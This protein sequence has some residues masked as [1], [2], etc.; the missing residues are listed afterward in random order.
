MTYYQRKPSMFQEQEIPL[1]LVHSLFDQ[2][3]KVKNHHRVCCAFGKTIRREKPKITSLLFTEF[4]LPLGRGS[5]SKFRT[6][7]PR[8]CPAESSVPFD[9]RTSSR[10]RFLRLTVSSTHTPVHPGRVFIYP[11]FPRFFVLGELGPKSRAAGDW[12]RVG[13][14]APT[15]RDFGPSSPRARNLGNPEWWSVMSSFCTFSFS[16]LKPLCCS[17]ETVEK[18]LWLP[19]KWRA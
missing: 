8:S 4:V 12:G 3:R 9:R 14:E 6:S 18:S 11:G 16:S 5:S 17:G 7:R 2:E 19:G 10:T 1:S 15:A 13:A